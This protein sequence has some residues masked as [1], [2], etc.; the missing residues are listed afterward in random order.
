MPGA[1]SGHTRPA[2]VIEIAQRIRGP[3]IGRQCRLRGENSHRIAVDIEHIPAE[4]IGKLAAVLLLPLNAGPRRRRLP[5]SSLLIEFGAALY[6]MRFADDLGV[7]VVSIKVLAGAPTQRTVGVGEGDAS[8][9][10]PEIWCGE[11]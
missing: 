5:S 1:A 6:G 9:S 11:C 3:T 4:A 2:T 10:D 8:D 7:A